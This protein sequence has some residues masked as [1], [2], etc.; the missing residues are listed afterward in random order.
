MSTNVY[1]QHVLG[2]EG[3]LLPGAVLPL[4]HELF[5]ALSDVVGIQVLQGKENEFYT[6]NPQN[7]V[8]VLRII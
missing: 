8:R 6:N 3:F 1:D 5:L 7:L 4:T 2:F